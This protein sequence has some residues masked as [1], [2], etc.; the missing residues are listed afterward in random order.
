[1]HDLEFNWDKEFASSTFEAIDTGLKWQAGTAKAFHTGK[2]DAREQ[3]GLTTEERIEAY[4]E[5]IV[6]RLLTM[7][8]DELER[9]VLM[10]EEELYGR[11]LRADEASNRI[12]KETVANLLR[13]MRP[14]EANH[15]S[16]AY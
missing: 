11:A 4:L 7:D 8:S 6:A 15:N 3:N 12:V 9:E 10:L 1:M 5:Q 13:A 14:K 16:D 2:A